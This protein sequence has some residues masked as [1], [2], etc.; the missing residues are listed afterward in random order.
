MNNNEASLRQ[1]AERVRVVIVNYKSAALT[2]ACL[3]SLQTEVQADPWIRVVVVENASGDADALGRAIHE[4]GWET[5]VSLIIAEQNGGFSYGN[6]RGIE[7]ALKQ[8]AP[9]AYFLLLNPDTEVRKGAI[10]ALVEYMDAHKTVGIAGSSYENEDGSEWPIAF[11]FH[12]VWSQL[13]SAVRLGLVSRVLR[14]WLVAKTMGREPEQTDWV[15]G[16]SMMI[17][18]EVID[19]I[20][21][22]DEGYFLYFEEVDYCLRALRAGWPCWY[23]PQSRIMHISGQSTGV[24][25][26]DRNLKRMPAYWFASRSRY[27]VKNH[28]LAYARLT[29]L[30]FGLGL[31]IFSLRRWILRQTDSNPPGMFADFWKS[32]VLFCGRAEVL[33]RIDGQRVIAEI[34]R[35][36]A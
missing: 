6:N 22:M 15:A 18:R 9:P 4:N 34:A 25:G 32:S 10:R 14:G 1:V 31:G 20:G 29:D 7:G 30:A 3:R 26:K 17:R 24:S 19:A 21:L 27:F 11:R 28:G 35:Q 12:T 2:I 13:E 16:A 36:R 33:R 5:W 8:A 23:V